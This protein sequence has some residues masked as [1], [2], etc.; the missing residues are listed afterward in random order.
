MD[1]RYLQDKDE[2]KSSA[3]KVDEDRRA[4]LTTGLVGGAVAAAALASSV[5]QAQTTPAAATMTPFWPHPKWGKD[6]TAGGSN[7][8]TPTKV[9]DT[10]K[11][12]KDGKIYR[13][14]R[15][16]ETGMPKFGERAFTMRI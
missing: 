8:I 7:W 1:A 14:G 3:D 6:D 4:L 9:L 15:V 13:I 10:V 5:A 11:W 16:Y 2:L 12:I